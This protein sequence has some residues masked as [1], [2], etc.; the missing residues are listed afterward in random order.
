MRYLPLLCLTTSAL[1]LSACAT[2]NTPALEGA[3]YEID[4]LRTAVKNKSVS[5]TTKYDQGYFSGP[6]DRYGADYCDSIKDRQLLEKSVAA[7]APN[8]LPPAKSTEARI[9][10]NAD[11]SC[12]GY[13]STASG[14]A[15]VAQLLSL[16]LVK[17]VQDFK[18]VL[19]VN[20]VQ[21]GRTLFSKS[22]QQT[23]SA[24]IQQVQLVSQNN[25]FNDKLA[26]H[27][28]LLIEKFTKDLSREGALE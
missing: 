1:L 6:R 24:P 17:G 7:W 23:G 5:V 25:L 3:K 4:D 20:V 19:K 9:V 28:G 22:Y 15:A 26:E 12:Y 2:D 14:G 13:Y 16:G 11:W 8:L 18:L 27:A 10:V 21:G